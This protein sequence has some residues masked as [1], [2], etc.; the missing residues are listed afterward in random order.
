MRSRVLGVV[1]ALACAGC[2]GAGTLGTAGVVAGPPVLR[3]ERSP[4]PFAEVTIG[5]VQALVPDRW[6][7]V[8]SGSGDVRNG[9]TATP[10]RRAWER[11]DGSA[12]GMAATWI[13]A[14][15]VGVPSDFYY[16]AATGPLLS[17]LIHSRDCRR[18]ARRVFIDDR[19]SFLSG[20]P[21]SP[22]DY[23]ATGRGRC[24]V[25]GQLTRWAYFIAEPGYGPVHQV[26]I[27]SS[28]LYVIVAMMQDSPSAGA[29]LRGLLRSTR[30]GGAGIRDFVVAARH[31]S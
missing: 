24:D 22:G 8:A 27:P 4:S 18:D 17:G 6:M 2:G 23:V 7:P 3:I 13:D 10:D 26:G 31:T 28:G 1:I 9:F 14:T 20:H 11:M 29:T 12:V 15:R 21:D 16:L 19:P 5:P 30:F 25:A